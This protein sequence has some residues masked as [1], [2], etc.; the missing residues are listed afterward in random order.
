MKDDVQPRFAD[1][2]QCN[3]QSAQSLSRAFVFT[4]QFEET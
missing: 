2:G 1:G 3:E 4:K